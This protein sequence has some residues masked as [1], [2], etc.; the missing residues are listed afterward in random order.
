MVLRPDRLQR[1]VSR[2]TTMS[3]DERRPERLETLLALFAARIGAQLRKD[4]LVARTVT[5]KLR[6]DDFRTVTR[7]ITLREGTQL[8]AE[9]LT[10]ALGLFREAF[11]NVRARNRGVRL[12]GL[13]ATNLAEA[14]EADLFESD[15]RQR[16][17]RL[18]DAVDQL[19]A[20]YGFDAVTIA[21]LLDVQNRRSSEK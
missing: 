12:I 16:S 14:A 15:V 2:E 6:H 11:D 13:S 19:R 8:D 17:R 4:G 21:R 5:L 1:S 20:R 10:P 3:R 7:R 9:L 18:T